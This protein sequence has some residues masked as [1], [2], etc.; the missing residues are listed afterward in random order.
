MKLKCKDGAMK[1]RYF[2]VPF[3]SIENF[4]PF[5]IGELPEFNRLISESNTSDEINTS[6]NIY[7]Y[8]VRKENGWVWLEEN[9]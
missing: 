3:E 6:A 7:Y 8:R 4:Y 9:K 5:Q 2:E 1:G